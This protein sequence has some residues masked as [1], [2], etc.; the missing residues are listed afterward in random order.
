M[1][2]ETGKIGW[3]DLTVENAE[4][5]RDFYQSVVGWDTSAVSLGDYDDF[6][7]HP[8]GDENPIG[9]ICHKRG[10][11]SSMPSQWMVYITVD[12][13]DKSMEECERRGGN[14]VVRDRDMG[15]YG[16]LSVLQDPAGAF[17]AIIQP[18]DE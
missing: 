2:S 17:L 14:I 5:I 1:G 18:K 15:P 16:R 11:N 8:P 13:L 12:D 3:L 9:G 7:V 4:E 6:C 10:A